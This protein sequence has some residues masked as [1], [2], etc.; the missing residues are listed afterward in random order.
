MDGE[1]HIQPMMGLFTVVSKYVNRHL[2]LGKR[3]TDR[4]SQEYSSGSAAVSVFSNIS[5][6]LQVKKLTI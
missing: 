1:N 6:D 2:L 5:A 3:F 4:M